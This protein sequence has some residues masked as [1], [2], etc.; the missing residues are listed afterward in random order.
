MT[1]AL[2]SHE[3]SGGNKFWL[4]EIVL[5]DGAVDQKT[6]LIGGNKFD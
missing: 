5:I 3:G 6:V 1:S 4:V 2:L